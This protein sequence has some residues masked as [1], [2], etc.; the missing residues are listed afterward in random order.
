MPDKYLPISDAMARDLDSGRADH[1][2][3]DDFLPDS[4]LQA[5]KDQNDAQA[6][7]HGENLVPISRAEA[8]RRTTFDGEHLPTGIPKTRRVIPAPYRRDRVVGGK[9]GKKWQ[10][11]PAGQV[12][13]GDILFGQGVV[14]R[15][16]TEVRHETVEGVEDV[17]TGVDALIWSG[18]DNFTVIDSRAVV[19]V[20]R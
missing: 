15:T 4:A 18:L 7:V 5:I 2:S 16:D 17:A 13:R 3:L 6:T 8:A 20:F 12:R 9:H 11:L 19:R 1:R 10:E 14:T